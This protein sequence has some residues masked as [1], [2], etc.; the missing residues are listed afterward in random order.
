MMTSNTVEASGVP[1]PILLAAQ[2]LLDGSAIGFDDLARLP[3]KRQLFLGSG[4]EQ[5]PPTKQ[6]RS[7]PKEPTSVNLTA[8][9]ASGPP[10]GV[11]SSGVKSE[12]SWYHSEWAPVDERLG[13]K[14]TSALIPTL[15]QRNAKMMCKHCKGQR[16]FNPTTRYKEHLLST[17]KEFAETETFLSDV[18]Q[19]DLQAVRAKRARKSG[20]Q[21]STNTE[22]VTKT[23]P[24]HDTKARDA[25][26]LLVRAVVRYN[27]PLGFL[28]SDE[29][30]R[31]VETVSHGVHRAP[32]HNAFLHQLA[33]LSQRAAGEVTKR[34]SGQHFFS[35]EC[36]ALVCGDQQYY[37]LTSKGQDD[38]VFLG[39]FNIEKSCVSIEK[40]CDA[41][42]RSTLASMGLKSDLCSSNRTIPVGKVASITTGALHHMPDTVEFLSQKYGLF[43]HCFHVPCFAHTMAQFMV[44]QL[45][46]EAIKHTVR[47][48]YSIATS[49]KAGPLNK[50]LATHNRAKVCIDTPVRSNF[51]T[52]IAMCAGLLGVK[53]ALQ[54]ACL[55]S[56]FLHSARATAAAAG[57]RSG[58]PDMEYLLGSSPEDGTNTARVPEA[59]LG[60]PRCAAAY[61]DIM[62]EGWWARLEAYVQLNRII[63]TCVAEVG[64][65]AALLSDAALAYLSIN[66]HISALT[67]DSFPALLSNGTDLAVFQMS[68]SNHMRIGMTDELCAA[69]LLDAR[70]HVREFVQSEPAL[71]GSE[72]LQNC[73]ST[74]V[75]LRA[76][77]V[78]TK[79][80]RFD[81]PDDDKIVQSKVQ[82]GM[83]LQDA[84]VL[85]LG[86]HLR[87]FLGVHPK[88]TTKKLKITDDALSSCVMGT[89]PMAFW[90]M[91]VPETVWLRLL[92]MRLLSARP[93]RCAAQRTWQAFDGVFM[94]R[95]FSVG[96]GRISQ[97]LWSRMNMHLVPHG[98]LPD[99]GLLHV[100]GAASSLLE[101]VAQMDEED[102][103]AAHAAHAAALAAIPS[104]RAASPCFY[105]D[106]QGPQCSDDDSACADDF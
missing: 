42:H 52:C 34:L 64:K 37:A 69:L 39:C 56:E 100:N 18:V 104:A 86:T 20:M 73:G 53:A 55:D 83:P 36:D 74:D 25:S 40:Q 75:I 99:S 76:L 63:L 94:Q 66:A 85:V 33:E 65:D 59:L 72:A 3:P 102:E 27:I 98:K 29:L 88:V 13:S 97:L 12:L 78:V 71:V 105:A 103:I 58:D 77:K 14:V 70:K 19:S 91:L 90:Q 95:R 45:K 82:H 48:A 41:I 28:F 62:N 9:Q 96:T 38:C 30:K 57:S 49:F 68:W 35:I 17:C 5:E 43:F 10:S 89:S 6:N 2:E 87:A 93:T 44:D 31:F 80:A 54:A 32:D 61:A 67:E 47:R 16:S 50:L 1:A 4:A 84:K 46:V 60:Q 51:Y 26:D 92:A 24:S 106:A 23:Y 15:K 21:A 8:S 101:A 11:R 81:V 22:T 7:S 79:R